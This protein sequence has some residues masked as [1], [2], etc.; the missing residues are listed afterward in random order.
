MTYVRRPQKWDI[1]LITS[2]YPN[3]YILNPAHFLFWGKSMLFSPGHPH[4]SLWFNLPFKTWTFLSAHGSGSTWI[5]LR[6]SKQNNYF[7]N[8]KLTLQCTLILSLALL[9][10]AL[11]NK[12]TTTNKK[13][14]KKKNWLA[15]YCVCFL[16]LS[17][18][19]LPS[20]FFQC[21]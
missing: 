4:H 18:F 19:F 5:L 7:A 16:C 12:F 8:I 14:T 2:F 21:I 11:P 6:L 17:H 10:L 13:Q 20:I 9:W 15:G 3:M 1:T